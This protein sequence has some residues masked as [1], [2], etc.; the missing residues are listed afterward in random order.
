MKLQRHSLCFA[1]IIHNLEFSE[2]VWSNL[3]TRDIYFMNDLLLFCLCYLSY[4]LKLLWL[5][6]DLLFRLLN[7]YAW[8]LNLFTLLVWLS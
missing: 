3:K 5:L 1:R 2:I 8:L 7:N 4:F 6:D